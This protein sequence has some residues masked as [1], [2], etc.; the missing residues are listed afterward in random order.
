MVVHEESV[1]SDNVKFKPEENQ[2]ENELVLYCY[3][4]CFHSQKVLMALYEKNLS[5][6]IHIVDVTKNEQ[7]QKWFLNINP[8][9]T[10]PVLKDGIKYIPSSKR[11]LNYL[12]DNFSNGEHKRLIP[13]DKGMK[14]KQTVVN[15]HEKLC[16][17]SPFMV[18]IGS[19]INNRWS[20]D[21][22]YP[23]SIPTT[24]R[25]Y[26]F[27]N[28]QFTESLL[29][30]AQEEEKKNFWAVSHDQYLATIDSIED[31]L[32][33][34]EL[35]LVDREK[36]KADWWLFTDSFTIADI[37]F[38]M[39]LDRLSRL[40]M[41]ASMWTRGVRPHIDMYFQRAQQRKSYKKTIPT[42]KTD[43]TF[44]L[45]TRSHLIIGFSLVTAIITGLVGGFI[46]LKNK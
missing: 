21:F 23:Y 41:E 24:I 9:G 35:A 40:G 37:S 25:K 43:I 42:I 45:K 7:Y 34:A 6:T 12:E 44:F 13:I 38:I 8:R 5:F 29:Q 20:R 46:L 17:I 31:L 4:H 28:P 32:N 30:R 22:K 27:E 11:I 16:R 36:D 15:F 2:N 3:H 1:K 33:E 10:I 39:L 19:F 26:A 14:T 18:T